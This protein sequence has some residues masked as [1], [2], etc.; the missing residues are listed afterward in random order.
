MVVHVEKI[1]PFGRKSVVPIT[2]I[3]EIWE[4]ATPNTTERL[5]QE[6]WNDYSEEDEIKV[7]TEFYKATNGESWHDSTNWLDESVPVS[8]WF[9]VGVG[10]G[11][12]RTLELAGNNLTGSLPASI[13]SLDKLEIVQL[14]YNKIS[15]E[16][17]PEIGRLQN[18]VVF[19]CE[20]NALTGSLPEDIGYCANL[21]ALLLAQNKLSGALPESLGSLSKLVD[22]NMWDNELTDLPSSLPM[23][24]RGLGINHNCLSGTVPVSSIVRCKNLQ[25]LHMHANDFEDT[26]AAQDKIEA[27]LPNCTVVLDWQQPMLGCCTVQ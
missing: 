13:G 17:P 14:R 5:E 4:Q 2:Q 18:L 1:V 7:L 24:L 9:G 11:K 15:G 27:L 3:D 22:L 23:S 21:Q 10:D 12:V 26:A 8:A 16:L 6:A 19:D 25:V 20:A